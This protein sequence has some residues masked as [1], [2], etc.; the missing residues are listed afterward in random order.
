MPRPFKYRCIGCKPQVDYF[1]PRG[2][3]VS[4][5][6]EINLTMDEFEAIRLAD[7]EGLYQERAAEKMKVSRQTFGN[8][9][10]SAHKKM[11]DSI[12]NGKALKIEGGVYKMARMKKFR[13][14]D[15]NHEW[16]IP[17][18]TG[19]PTE[20]PQCKSKNIHRAEQDRGYTRVGRGVGFGYGKGRCRRLSI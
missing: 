20:C 6:E 19:R 17:Y 14:Y 12:V 9:I 7:L 5:L 11:A 3:P 18:G 8:I 1:K 15:Y 2:I 10:E 13:C 16:E 4:E